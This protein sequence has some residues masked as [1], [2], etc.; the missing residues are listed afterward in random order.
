[1]IN[2]TCSPQADW[3][4]L[5]EENLALIASKAS[6]EAEL[7]KSG[8]PKG[9]VDNTKVQLSALEHQ[10]AEQANEVCLYLLLADE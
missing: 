3:Q 1:V 5:E 6:L 4:K 2:A 7:R 10:V 9:L 8:G